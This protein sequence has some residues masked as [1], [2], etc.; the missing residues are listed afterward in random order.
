M[1]TVETIQPQKAIFGQEYGASIHITYDYFEILKLL[2][3]SEEMQVL[4][5]GYKNKSFTLNFSNKVN[6]LVTT[7]SQDI[8]ISI[9]GSGLFGVGSFYT[10]NCQLTFFRY[11]NSLLSFS[12]LSPGQ[13]TEA[14]S[15]KLKGASEKLR[16]FLF[17]LLLRGASKRILLDIHAKYDLEYVNSTG[18]NRLKLVKNEPYINSN[19]TEMR[20]LEY[21]TI[22]MEEFYSTS[23]IKDAL[24]TMCL[25]DYLQKVCP[26]ADIEFVHSNLPACFP[27]INPSS[28][29]IRVPETREI[30]IEQHI[31]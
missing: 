16:Q 12:K 26:N 9:P 20:Y 14:N 18:L 25:Q 8:S 3:T 6:P 28:I 2:L 4:S 13:L 29:S 22:N 21:Q 27:N 30:K 19:M 10:G 7:A 24:I 31:V 1:S 11:F 5:L 23:A 17:A 15:D